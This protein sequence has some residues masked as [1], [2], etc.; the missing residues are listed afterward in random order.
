MLHQDRA[1]SKGL[2]ERKIAVFVPNPFLLS[3]LRQLLPKFGVGDVFQT[4]FEDW[5]KRV[6][7]R[8]RRQINQLTDETASVIFNPKSTAVERKAAWA[9]AKLR[10]LPEM[11][12]VLRHLIAE[13]VRAA[14]TDLQLELP[15]PVAKVPEKELDA[16]MPGESEEPVEVAP[17]LPI[18]F[19]VSLASLRE[20]IEEWQNY[21]T[22]PG[23]SRLN[24]E[25]KAQLRRLAYTD[26]PEA[27]NKLAEQERIEAHVWNEEL[28]KLQ[29]EL[30]GLPDSIFKEA[31]AWETYLTLV[32]NR[33][34]VEQAVARVFSGKALNNAVNAL[35]RTPRP[36]KKD[37]LTVFEPTDVTELPLVLA[38]K[39]ILEGVRPHDAALR[40][41]FGNGGQ[42]QYLIVDEGQD[43]SPLQYAL[44][45]RYAKPGHAAVFGDLRQGIHR[46]R[47]IESWDVV[48]EAL[49]T[50]TEQVEELTQ[51]F[52]TTQEITNLSNF[53]LDEVMPT[54]LKAE[55]VPRPGPPVHF[56]R[57][58]Q[59]QALVPL[60]THEVR[61]LQGEGARNIGLITRSPGEAAALYQRIRHAGASTFKVDNRT[62]NFEDYKG[63]IAIVPIGVAKGL[64]FDAAIVLNAD[65]EHFSPD[66]PY[67]G[68][69]L[70]TSV[71]RGLHHLTIFARGE[72]TP[73]L[74]QVPSAVPGKCGIS[75][76]EISAG[77]FHLPPAYTMGRARQKGQERGPGA[78]QH[79]HVRT[80]DGRFES[81]PSYEGDGSRDNAWYDR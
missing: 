60:L 47:G 73:L 44:L 45:R 27:L 3:Y 55:A 5:A 23:W 13:H 62:Q 4:T 58:S 34:N 71:T 20:K 61:R 78:N 56:V 52:R 32:A 30:M 17:P 53:V 18:P 54:A 15:R 75:G 1:D 10:G 31:S 65:K 21:P 29:E 63:G 46:Y 50:G 42:F 2:E 14:L 35:H 59:E 8:G 41:R 74:G 68:S 19:A 24:A 33:R 39:L 66:T 77:G 64:E 37:E 11:Q 9:R 26:L 79:E 70:Y 48:I 80:Y 67:D 25:L 43:L 12:N 72:F 69:L 57:Y 51:T 76:L 36:P 7:N 49:G 38:L 6:V 22:Q 16:D 40:D 81:T 28:E